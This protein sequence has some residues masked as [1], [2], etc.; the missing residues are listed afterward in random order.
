MDY[1]RKRYDMPWLKRG[2]R[3]VALG[4]IGRVTSCRYGQVRV[5]VDGERI[6]RTFPPPDVKEHDAIFATLRGDA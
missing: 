3:V 1:V 4:H 5:L 6:P 2:V